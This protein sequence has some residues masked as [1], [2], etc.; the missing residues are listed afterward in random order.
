MYCGG[1]MKKSFKFFLSIFLLNL[2]MIAASADAYHVCVASYKQ[3]KNADEMVA[4][5]EKQSMA[6]FVSESKIKGESYYRVLLSKEFKKIEDARKYRDEVKDYSFVKELK[7][8]GFWVCKGERLP[9]KAKPVEKP[10]PKPV[11]KPA[12][13]PAPKP[14]PKPEPIPEPAVKNIEPPVEEPPVEEAPV[15]PPVA[16]EKAPVIMVEEPKI[17]DKN[18]KA[19]LSEK[20][21]YS[22]LVRSY[23]FSQFAQNDNLRL[24]E[25]GFDSYL[26]NT[27]DEKSFFSFN[28][29][30]GAF[31]SREEAEALS[32]QFSE[33]GIIETEVS[34]YREIEPKI[35]RYDEIVS[36]EHIKF[37]D[38]HKEMPSSIPP[39][40]EK[41]VRQFPANKDFPIQEIF[42]VDFDAY[43]IG[44]KKPELPSNILDS[45]GETDSVH[46]AL[47][48]EYR[49]ELYR[50][51]VSVFFANADTFP[52][53]DVEGEV[54]NMQFGSTD[55]FFE[56][57]LYEKKGELVLFGENVAEKMYVRISSKDFSKEE[58]INFLIDSF[59][60]GEL[61]LYPQMR[62]SF[63]VLPDATPDSPRDFICFSYKRVADD[64]ASKRGNAAWAMPIVGHSL[65]KSYYAEKNDLI[66]VGF[67][68]LDY[69]FNAK[70]VHQHFTDAK[71]GTEISETNQPVSVKSA[72]GWYM[73][74]SKQQ[75]ASFSTKSYVIAIDVEPDAPFQKEDLLRLGEDLKIWD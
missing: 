9:A 68:D 42:L 33:A 44:Q 31:A 32:A 50:K 45:T 14:E 22:V 74:N 29:H 40:V 51:T 61:S 54:E 34:D 18:E 72:E 49:D 37:D 7:L 36:T 10:A 55:G 62:R 24:R 3:L 27:F 48:A 1:I 75:E 47:L 12:P 39:L 21:P 53:D 8:K 23:K 16:E 57:E 43:R 56:C 26:L 60:D 35:K 58:F 28:I 70:S 52:E 17:L 64:Y 67:Y 38:G 11:A 30:A 6:A 63:Y 69:D 15:E 5:L 46:T 2:F 71:N 41:L 4:R 20:T 19:V 73:V 59:N 65:A 25:L 66:T 13:K